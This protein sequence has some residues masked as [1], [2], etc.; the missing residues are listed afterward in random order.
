[1]AEE[2]VSIDADAM[3]KHHDKSDVGYRKELKARHIRMIAIGGAIGSGLFYGAAG[4]LHDGGPGIAL[5]YLLCGIIAY[6][7][8]RALGEMTLYRPSSGGFIS[9]ARE[10]MGE[11][12][13]FFTGWFAFITWS[14]AMMADITAIA[15]YMWYWEVFR[16]IPKW[17]WALIA[18]SI[19]VA[20]N[21]AA[22]KFFGEFE[23]WF[24]MIK[25]AAIIIFMIVAIVVLVLGI[26]VYAAD[27]ETGVRTAYEPGIHLISEGG[28]IFPNGAFTMV[29]LSIGV[30]F[31]FGG[32]EYIGLAAGEAQNPQ[33]EM[34]R[35]VNSLMWRILLFYVGSMILFSLLLPHN[36]YKDG[37][38]PFVT[39][40]AG[41]G[42][43]AADSIM[44][45]VV[46]IA[47]VSAINAELYTAGRGLRALAMSGSAPKILRGMNRNAVPS[48][49][50]FAAGTIGVIGV[51]VN[52][53]VPEQ[54]FVIIA[55][56]AGVGICTMWG[57]IMI[58]NMIFVRRCNRG[59]LKRPNF[60]L[61]AAP[62][63][64]ILVLAVLVGMII[65]MWWEGGTGP[66]VIITFACIAVFLALVWLLI[67]GR[68]DKEM[69][70]A[71]DKM[72]TSEAL[73]D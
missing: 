21:L 73:E 71:I 62:Y 68:V 34:P 69:F 33:R 24:A 13:A 1:M 63:T 20:I 10:F 7:M 38:S 52:L 67:R 6:L 64:N 15:G 54:A 39:F 55:S 41:I 23:F 14:T 3:A 2:K 26:N 40:F 35:A 25:V 18:L 31:A 70:Q 47:A 37:E 49:A 53:V 56:L 12:G 51:I 43:P 29:T 72:D 8:L 32:T 17:A 66:V 50:I 22:V 19:V 61:W 9:Y 11:G 4:R 60:H 36:V 57:S 27:P 45:L 48:S 42:L 28:G 16:V 44:N 65:L 5:L 59:E 58:S 46:M 30:L